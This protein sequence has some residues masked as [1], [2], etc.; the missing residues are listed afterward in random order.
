MKLKVLC[1]KITEVVKP[2]CTIQEA[3]GLTV[4]TGKETLFA[5]IITDVYL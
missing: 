3:Q 5:T 4:N 2:Y 1:F